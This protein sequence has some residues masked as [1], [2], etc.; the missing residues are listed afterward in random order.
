MSSR[1]GAPAGRTIDRLGGAF[2]GRDLRLELTPTPVVVDP[3]FLD[4]AL[5]NLLENAVKFAGTGA[6]IRVAAQPAGERVRLVIEDGGPG[7]PADALERIF[8]PFYRGMPSNRSD[9]AGT[10]IGLAVVRG[11]IGA[12]GGTTR[13]YRSPLGGLAVEL[14]LPMAS[15]PA[16]LAPVP[17]PATPS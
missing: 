10:G 14:D 12:M 7:V 16:E 17:T 2:A 1:S 6:T 9:R 3:V 8:D 13:A 5:T 11:L 4:E 15:L